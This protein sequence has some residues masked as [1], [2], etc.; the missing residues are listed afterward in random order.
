MPALKYQENCQENI[1]TILLHRLSTEDSSPPRSGA[2]ICKLTKIVT[3]IRTYG[4]N[5]PMAKCS[6]KAPKIFTD[7]APRSIQL[8][9]VMSV[10]VLYVNMLS[11]RHDIYLKGLFPPTSL[12]HWPMQVRSSL[13]RPLIGPVQQ[14]SKWSA[15]KQQFC[16]DALKFDPWCT[17]N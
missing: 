13:P 5:W 3:D 7:L 14:G 16:V 8:V 2:S 4:L 10:C 1:N 12:P 17:V 11:P 9:V 15:S 6:E